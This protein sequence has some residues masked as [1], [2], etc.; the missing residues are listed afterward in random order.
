M[1]TKLKSE[2]ISLQLGMHNE[3]KP[4]DTT[5]QPQKI[6]ST[7]GDTALYM[8]VAA[9]DS[10]HQAVEGAHLMALTLPNPD[11]IRPPDTDIRSFSR[12]AASLVSA[13]YTNLYYICSMVA[14]SAL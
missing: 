13:L 12:I 5:A 2:Q 6:P 3:R 11:A 7:L 9:I 8:I 4:I 14:L 1:T 10:L